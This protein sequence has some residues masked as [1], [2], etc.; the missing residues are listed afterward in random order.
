MNLQGL[1]VCRNLLDAEIFDGAAD[2]FESAARLI[3][4]AERLGLSGNLYRTYLIYLLAHEPNVI[5]TSIEMQGGK[6]GKSLR[7]IFKRDV[8]LLLP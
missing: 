5:S 2:E 6:I 1:I 3:E 4:H 8:E 7:E